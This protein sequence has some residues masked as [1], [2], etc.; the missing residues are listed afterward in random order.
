MKDFPL[1]IP[2]S[3]SIGCVHLICL[4]LI[5]ECT[6]TVL[7]VELGYF[8]DA[9][10][11]AGHLSADITEVN[12]ESMLSSADTAVLTTPHQRFS[13]LPT[14]WLMVLEGLLLI[15]F[16]VAVFAFPFALTKKITRGHYPQFS[17]LAM[18]HSGLWLIVAIIDGTLQFYHRLSRN[19]GYLKCYRKTRHIRRVPFYCLSTGNAAMLLMLGIYD[20][21]PT[22]VLK[23]Y[24]YVEIFAS[25]EVAV[26]LPCIIYYIVYVAKFNKRR[27]F[28]DLDEE[29][30]LN[31]GAPYNSEIITGASRDADYLDDILEKQADMIRYLQQHNIKLGK[32]LLKLSHRSNIAE[33]PVPIQNV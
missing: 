27:P 28:P 8:F 26:C 3:D 10:A 1:M 9:D 15:I 25:I 14:V 11:D 24:H 13:T 29:N 23:P 12:A 16:E 19:H 17:L 31:C 18:F 33:S 22:K 21:V 4:Q 6:P 2:F 30:V 7:T 5:G 32:R 20:T